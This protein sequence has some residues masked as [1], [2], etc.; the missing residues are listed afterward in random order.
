[1]EQN[2]PYSAPTAAISD[3]QNDEGFG[4]LKIFTSKGRIGRIRYLMYTMGVGLIGLLLA[5]LLMV[6]PVIGPFLAI[7]L[8]IG[9]MV[10]SIFL[11]IQRS[12]DFNTT[13]WLSLVILIPLVSLIF[14]FIPGTKGS[15]KYGLQPPPNGKAIK[16]IAFLLLAFFVLGILASIAIPAYQDYITRAAG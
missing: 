16:I 14:Y 15:N 10:I 7:A 5:A 6:I 2:N 9:I 8:Y 13:G 3:I 11:T 12:H 4:D 1:M